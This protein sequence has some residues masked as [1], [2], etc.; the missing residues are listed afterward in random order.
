MTRERLNWVAHNYLR[1]AI[2]L[3]PPATLDASAGWLLSVAH[4]ADLV[5]TENTSGPN[6]S[7]SVAHAAPSPFLAAL[8]KSVSSAPVNRV[9]GE[10]A[11]T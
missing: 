7:T 6:R 11:A 5:V 10:A 8:T 9:L 3:Q 2:C 1:S 4:P